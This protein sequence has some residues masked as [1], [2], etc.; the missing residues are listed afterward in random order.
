MAYLEI[1]N[2]PED[3]TPAW[4][5]QALRTR[6]TITT[7][8]VAS[9]DVQRI[10]QGV[11]FI[12]QLVRLSMRYTLDEAG[13]PRS[14]IAKFPAAAAEN[15]ALGN[16]FRF[17]ERETRFYEE[18][19]A[20]S[21][22]RTPHCYYSAIDSTAGRNILLL[23]DLAPARV[24]DQVQGCTVPEAELAIQQLAQFHAAWWEQPRL[25]TFDW[26]PLWNDAGLVPLVQGVYQQA[27]G[28]FLANFGDRLPAAL[29]EVGQRLGAC[30]APMM[31]Q[32][33]QPPRTIM[34]GD[35]RIDNLFFATTAEGMPLAVIDWQICA[36][37]R[38][39]FDVAYLLSQSAPPALR[40]AE[41][42]RLLRTYHRAL[43][44]HG[45]QGYAFEECLLDYRRSI[46]FALVYP[47]IVCGSL[48]LAN[49]RGHQL[50]TVVLERSVA[51]ILDLNAAE[52]LPQ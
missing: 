9:F 50:A 2:G 33:A 40:Q 17:Y 19:A 31:D 1:P 43:L 5:T 37:G 47:V 51:A 46:L 20:K 41:E 44:D 3:L 23:E 32:L 8:A 12:G 15:R 39:V 38:G 14:L 22:L 16:M 34:H 13:A 27:W 52:L 10:A 18:I 6:G 26:M 42:M 36:R 28:P 49:A 30:I 24:G 7:A 4:L 35:Y 45:V 25:S 11:G 48:D 29:L 21:P